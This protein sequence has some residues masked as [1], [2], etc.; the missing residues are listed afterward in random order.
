MIQFSANIMSEVN[1]GNVE[2]FYL[3]S[4]RNG[5]GSLERASTTHAI[6]ITMG[7]GV[8]YLANDQIVAADPPK[9][10]TTVDR[11][12]YRVTLADPS[13][14]NAEAADS[15]M[16][17]KTLETRIGFVNST[18]GLPYTAMADTFIIY[19]GRI[20][21][22]A[23]TVKTA[24][25][26]ESNLDITCASPMAVLDMKKPLY[27]SKDFIRGRQASDSSCDQVYEGSGSLVLKWGK[28]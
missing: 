11:E 15:G 17:G 16:V 27:L 25:L 6:A 20:D 12:Q 28:K 22:A 7:D 21:G 18:T 26:G 8:T 9:L 1:A 10:S 19:K 24:E 5:D 13:F 14:E 3:L 2:T 23:L 4:I